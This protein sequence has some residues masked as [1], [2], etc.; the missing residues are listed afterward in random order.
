[1]KTILL[2]YHDEDAGRSALQVATVIA[3]R[4]SSFLMGLLVEEAPRISFDRRIPVPA[5][6]LSDYARQ[7]RDFADASRQHFQTITH[8]RGFATGEL[9]TEEQGPLAGWIEL[10]GRESQVVGE[11]G[12]LFDL[13]VIGRTKAAAT[14]RW[15]ETCEAALFDSGRPVLL[16]G[17][18]TPQDAQ[19]NPPR[20]TVGDDIVI[21]W[22]G[23]TESA[24]TVALAMPLLTAAS[25]VIVLSVDGAMVPGPSGRDMAGHLVR[26][27]I[28]AEAI[29]VHPEGRDTGT[30]ILEESERLHADLLV[31]GAYTRSRLRQVIFGGATAHV[32]QNATLPVLLAH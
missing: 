4:F 16:T 17:R 21:A 13:I 31:K 5:E 22:N 14:G 26:H 2:P 11:Y 28:A 1:M 12:R 19:Q 7:W 9:E 18:D 15:Q 30:A 24:R 6:Y 25:H 23:S 32:M 27:G 29:T 10:E 3:R 20:N 8:E